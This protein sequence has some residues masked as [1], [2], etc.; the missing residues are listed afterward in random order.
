MNNRIIEL[1]I[2]EEFLDE[3]GVDGIAL[4][5]APAI[6]QDFYWFAKD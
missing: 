2:N 6:E 3:S 5:S 1:K 4:V